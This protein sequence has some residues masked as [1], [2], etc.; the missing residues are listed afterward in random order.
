MTP[1]NQLRRLALSLLFLFPLAGC[2]APSHGGATSAPGTFT[3]A[4]TASMP[5]DYNGN[6]GRVYCVPQGPEFCGVVVM[7]GIENDPHGTGIAAP[8]LNVNLHAW[9]NATDMNLRNLSISLIAYN[10]SCLN[11]FKI[12][13]SAE[14]PSPLGLKVVNQTFPPGEPMAGI[15]GSWPTVRFRVGQAGL[16]R[17]RPGL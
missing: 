13:Q 6:I 15:L 5:I 2:F 16:E 14:G 1:R 10:A 3:P 7:D 4:Q 12:L 8:S 9:W 11:C 17:S